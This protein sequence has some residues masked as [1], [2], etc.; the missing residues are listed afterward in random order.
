MNSKALSLSIFAA[1]AWTLAVGASL[2]WNVSHEDE[3]VLALANTEAKSNLDR[4]LSLRR[5]ATS[6]G[7]V[8]VRVDEK[9][10]PN[11]FLAGIPER[12]VTTPSGGTLTLLNPATMLREIKEE[13]GNLFGH[14]ARIT[15]LKII[16]PID[17]PDEWE[18]K[19]LLAIEQSRIDYTEVTTVNGKPYLRRMQPMFMEEGCLKCHAW[20]GI[21]VGEVRG[22]T[23]IAIPLEPYAALATQ[24]KIRYTNTHGGIWLF[25]LAAIAFVARRQER[26][27]R[28]LAAEQAVVRRMGRALDQS[29]NGVLITDPSGVIEYANAA[30]SRIN[31]YAIDELLGQTPAI[32]KSGETDPSVY[33]EL[34]AALVRGIEWRGEF[35]NRKKNGEIYWCLE[36]ISPIRNDAGETTHFVAVMEDVSERKFAEDTIRRLALHDPLT[37]LPNRRLLRERLE[38]AVAWSKRENAGVALCYVDLD[39][40]K[41]VNDTLGHLV[42]DAMLKAVARRFESCLRDSDTLARLGGDEFAVVVG[43]VASTADARVVVE[44]L[45]E[46]IREPIFMDNRELRMTASIGISVYPQDAED[47]DTLI[48]NADAAMYHAKAGGKNAY[49]FFT[50]EMADF[51]VENLEIETALHKAAERGELRLEY[52]PLVRVE[53]EHLDGLEALVRWQHPVLGLIPPGR[54]I[55]LAEEIGE[56]K[57]I[58]EWVLREACRQGRRWLDEGHELVVSVNI[59]AVQFR[60]VELPHLVAEVLRESGLPGRL[61]ELEITESAL[62]DNPEAAAYSLRILRELGV[63]IAIDDFGTGYSSLAYLKSFPVSVLKIDKSFVDA[64][65]Q[66]GLDRSII[67][68]VVTLAR[69][70]KLEVV[71]EGVETQGQAEMLR[72][73]GCDLL[74]G[75]LISRPVA[76]AVVDALLSRQPLLRLQGDHWKI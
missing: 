14:L 40:F 65:E 58:G 50:A 35:K 6:H 44:K 42:G 24:A 10:K 21:K 30:F 63:S 36:T 57:A 55:A 22:G 64:V 11:P 54:F 60:D 13:Q 19:A 2:L 28:K 74:Q 17:A 4:D 23:D 15:A 18:K 5:W 47:I 52:Q 32:L 73:L 69:S 62:M 1:I 3:R 49:R 71:A 75:Y 31:G 39:R 34:W 33:R 76:P 8:Y 51:S 7:G 38:Q 66:P 20:T 72:Y 43:N 68:A 61:L 12:D 9:N 41:T 25:G 46:S 70:L 56:I 45:V 48:R 59:S 67:E 27:E 29:N 53:G 26:Q 37:D 16:N